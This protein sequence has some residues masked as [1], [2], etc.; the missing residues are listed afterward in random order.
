MKT[1][2]WLRRAVGVL[3]VAVLYASASA[4]V[5][6]D[7]T[8]AAGRA[9]RLNDAEGQVQISQGGET[10]AD[11]ALVNT[12]IFEGMQVA[13][14]DD[15]RAEIQFDDGSLVR[16]PP[17]SS[18]TLT[19]LKA[20]GD[21]EILLESGMGYFELQGN[22]ASLMRVRFASNVVTVSGFTVLRLKLDDGPGALAVFSGNAHLDGTNG[23]SMDLHG[24]QS[25]ALSDLT[26]AESIEPDSWDAWNSDRDQAQTTSDVGSTPAT[27]NVADAN[28][29]AWNDL[30]S[31]GTWYDV[32]DQGY[33]W[34]P[35]EASNA[36]FDPYGQG[37][38]M[39]TPGYG[40]VWVSGYS[41]GYKPFQCGA[42]N[43]YN[44]F[45]WGW[46]PGGCNPW[47]GTGGGWVF[48]IGY[49]PPWYRLPVRPRPIRPL[50]PRPMDHT[51]RVGL[52]MH[53]IN[54]PIAVSRRELS[55][56]T[57]LPPREPD[58]PV[59]I[60]GVIANPVRPTAPRTVSGGP[61]IGTTHG[62]PVP[63]RPV[64]RSPVMGVNPVSGTTISPR[65]V[66]PP[67]RAGY[68]PAPGY[69]TSRPGYAPAPQPGGGRAPGYAPVPRPGGSGGGT[70]RP[71]SAP[72][73]SGG[74]GSH[75]APSG[76]GHP[77][78]GG[79]GSHPSGGGSHK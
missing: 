44:S 8:A 32:P 38:W 49:L 40:Y 26:L 79:G 20:G 42:W 14:G 67:A 48:N 29:P 54:P 55:G 66:Y 28:N 10:L 7:D 63:I 30:N 76:G 17:D 16:I 6:A 15:G 19:S 13:T 62:T 69:G 37:Y 78:G 25:V 52:H 64:N 70:Y 4:V 45:G 12:P 34:S 27:S 43:W 74:G 18:L 68:L 51:V 35:Y 5:W 60:G 47:W 3:A 65:P 11:P 71:P 24:G 75:P 36:G 22:Q 9:A 41:W 59:Q 61:V 23:A 31:D 33:V 72:R 1:G 58:H 56:T 50:N 53:P 77:S 46:A 73:P 39:F 2:L 21:T 57:G